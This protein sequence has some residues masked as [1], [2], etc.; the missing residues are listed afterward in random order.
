MNSISQN[1]TYNALISTVDTRTPCT[2][3]LFSLF[4][5]DHGDCSFGMIH[6]HEEAAAVVGHCDAGCHSPGCNRDAKE[7]GVGV[8]KVFCMDPDDTGLV[9]VDMMVQ[10]EGCLDSLGLVADC[11]LHYNQSHGMG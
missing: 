11:I 9:H 6:S 1:Q 5:T 8:V 4:N 3:T 10:D 2:H 7:E